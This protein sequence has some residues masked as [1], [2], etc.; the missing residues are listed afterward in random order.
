MRPAFRAFTVGKE[1]ERTGVCASPADMRP[2]RITNQPPTGPTA[3]LEPH[4][5]TRPQR[6]GLV[7]LDAKTTTAAALLKRSTMLLK[8]MYRKID[9]ARPDD[10][11]VPPRR[12]LTH[13]HVPAANKCA[14][15][16]LPLPHAQRWF[17]PPTDVLRSGP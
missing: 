7:Q 11:D 3:V 4:A 9:P 14:Q 10:C 2:S 1:V 5:F 8:D 13:P 17:A 16:Q 6:K 12:M 15:P